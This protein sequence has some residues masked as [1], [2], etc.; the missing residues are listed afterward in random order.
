MDAAC[1][2]F[3]GPSDANSGNP[4]IKCSW[5]PAAC[6]TTFPVPT[7]TRSHR[8]R[9]AAAR[10]SWA[11][12]CLRRSRTA[13]W[14]A[15]G[16]LHRP[17]RCTDRTA[18]RGCSRGERGQRTSSAPCCILVGYTARSEPTAG[19]RRRRTRCAASDTSRLCYT[20]WQHPG[21]GSPSSLQT[22]GRRNKQEAESISSPHC[23][24]GEHQIPGNVYQ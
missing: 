16:A 19:C 13:Q 8:G 3:S 9:A 23:V 22:L 4:S 18:A 17:C 20:P 21:S 15:S 6:K 10:G 12:P 24:V 2:Q 5:Q 14:F 11:C 1:C 7:C